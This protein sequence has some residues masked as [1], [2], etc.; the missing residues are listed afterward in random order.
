MI[1]FKSKLRKRLE[2]E[3]IRLTKENI[4][5]V[6]KKK[7]IVNPGTDNNYFKLSLKEM[8]NR[9]DIRLLTKILGI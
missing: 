7:A 6:K 9:N 3:I 5:L 2:A 8:D 4:E 1:F